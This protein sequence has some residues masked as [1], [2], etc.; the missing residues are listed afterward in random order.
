[1][2]KNKI[3]LFLY[4]TVSILLI[5]CNTNLSD[6][7]IFYRKA[8]NKFGDNTNVDSLTK[9]FPK[10]IKGKKYIFYN[11]PSTYSCISKY[12]IIYLVDEKS[13]YKNEIDRIIKN[14]IF[15]TPYSFQKN[16]IL[17]FINF[18]VFLSQKK[19]NIYHINTLPIPNFESFNFNLGKR[20]IKIKE[21]N[22][23]LYDY[24]F[25]V[26]KDLKVYVI[27]AKPGYFFKNNCNISRPKLLKEW[28]N[29]FSRGIAISEKENRVVFWTMLW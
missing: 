23:I 6:S 13:K 20:V 25:K 8:I 18:K 1:M 11:S 21:K 29:G 4:L 2:E 12:G 19:Y 22:N 15:N 28:Q 17:S 14:S 16:T 27:E 10:K 9:H 24:I 5:R 3:I 26:P 7:N